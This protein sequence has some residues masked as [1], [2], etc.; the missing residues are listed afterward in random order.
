VTPETTGRSRSIDSVA[1]VPLSQADRDDLVGHLDAIE[2]RLDTVGILAS[3]PTPDVF[4]VGL[5]VLDALALAW[6]GGKGKGSDAWED[7][8]HEFIGDD[9]EELYTDLRNLALHN[10]GASPGIRL[11]SDSEDRSLHRKKLGGH[12]Y[13]HTEEFARDVEEAFSRFRERALHDPEVGRRALFWFQRHAPVRAI[14]SN[15]SPAPSASGTS[16]YDELQ[17]GSP[18]A[19]AGQPREPSRKAVPKS[20]KRP[21]A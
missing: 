16:W 11:V 21:T 13:L 9:F 4:T 1:A 3:L 2:S 19:R 7:F 10:L 17:P 18:A 8:V 20:R 15:F 5:P 6:T 12:Y 14:A